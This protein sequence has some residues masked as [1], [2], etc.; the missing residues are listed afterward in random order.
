LRRNRGRPWASCR[1]AG[2]RGRGGSNGRL[3]SSSR[4]DTDHHEAGGQ[5]PRDRAHEQAAVLPQSRARRAAF[6]GGAR[7][8]VRVATIGIQAGGSRR[9]PTT[10]LVGSTFV[11]CDVIA[12]GSAA[13]QLY[14]MGRSGRADRRA[15]RVRGTIACPPC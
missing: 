15:I 13:A 2:R 7:R 11:H 9:Q 5:V 12:A 1:R 10:L 6:C 8:T 4:D 3:R 14:M